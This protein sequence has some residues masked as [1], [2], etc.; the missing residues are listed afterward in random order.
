[1]AKQAWALIPANDD[2]DEELVEKAKANRS[3]RIKVERS[4]EQRFAQSEGYTDNTVQTL[5]R[6]VKK[7]AKSGSQ[8]ESGDLQAVAAG[9]R[10]PWVGEFKKAT[11]TVN[12]SQRAKDAAQRV[13]T[14][15]SQV[16]SSAGSGDAAGA[17]RNFVSVVTAF[18]EWGKDTGVIG[19][20]SGL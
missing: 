5:Q 20:L 18:Q 11:E 6:A 19:R 8:L 13:F 10:D 14:S 4:T 17:K 9:L 3:S 1:L 2:E 16:G 12:S 7:L 15:L